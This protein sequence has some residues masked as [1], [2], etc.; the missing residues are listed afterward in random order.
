MKLH[1][2]VGLAIIAAAEALLFSGNVLVGRWLTPIVWTATCF[3]RRA[4]L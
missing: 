2:Y 1:G 4:R 3:C